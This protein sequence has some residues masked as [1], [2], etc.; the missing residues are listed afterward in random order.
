MS[1]S[2]KCPVCRET[3]LSRSRSMCQCMKREFRDGLDTQMQRSSSSSRPSSCSCVGEVT[4][5]AMANHVLSLPAQRQILA[6]GKFHDCTR[7]EDND[8]S[9]IHCQLY[10]SSTFYL[11]NRKHGYRCPRCYLQEAQ[12][13]RRRCLLCRV[14]RVLPARAG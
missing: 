12:V 5:R 11:Y 6:I 9:R 10:L 4:R 3:R 1:C 14:E 7:K 2:V 8:F 13:R